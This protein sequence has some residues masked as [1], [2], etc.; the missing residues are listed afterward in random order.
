MATGT[1]TTLHFAD[2]FIAALADRLGAEA[3]ARGGDL[4]R[5]A[6]V[7]GGRRPAM[8]LLR[9]LGRRLGG[10]FFPPRCFTMDAF[11]GHALRAL[12][13][14][15]AIPMLDAWHL[16]YLLAREL[17]PGMLEGRETFSRF[18]AWARETASFIDELDIEDVAPEALATMEHCAA[19]GLD[20][21]PGVENL[22]R[23]ITAIREGYH[24]AL[25]ARKAVSRGLTYLLVS[26]GI[27][28][29]PFG[30]FDRILFCGFFSLHRTEERVVKELY[31]RG[32]ADLWFQR[33]AEPWP[34][35]ERLSKALGCP[36]EPSAG[37]TKGGGPDVSL[38]A[39]FDTQTQVGLV[40]RIVAGIPDRAGTVIV[41]PDSG[42]VIPLVSELASLEP[43]FNVSMGY[44][45]KRSALCNLLD[46]VFEAQRGMR[47]GAYY[48]R[49]YL[50]VLTHPLVKNMAVVRDG[51]LTRVLVHKIEEALRGAAGS[52]IGG[53]QF[54]RP[55]D[56]E[57]MGGVFPPAAST[58]REMGIDARPGELEAVLAGL[59]ACAFRAWEG[60]ASF[61]EFG[62][63]LES[64]VDAL[65]R[66]SALDRY[67]LN[68]TFAGRLLAMASELGGAEAGRERFEKEE[69]FKL[70]TRMLEREKISFSGSPLRGLQVLGLMETRSLDFRNVVVM[71][72]NESVLPA[73]EG[74]DPLVPRQVRVSLGLDRVEQEEEI[75][76]YHFMRLISHA[77]KVHLVYNDREEREERSRFIEELVWRVQRAKGALEAV[78]VRRARVAVSLSPPE[79]RI[80]KTEEVLRLLKDFRHSPSS[81]DTYLQCPLRFYYGYVLRLREAEDLLEEPEGADIGRFVHRLLL[82]AFTPFIGERPRIDRRFREEF[83]G[84]MEA[85]FAETFEK[86]MRADSFIL[87]EVLRVR[88]GRF[89]DAEER[90]PVASIV[91]LEEPFRGALAF[92]S[93]EH[94]FFCRADRLDREPGG[95]ILVI[96]YKTG[97]ASLPA[98]PDALAGMELARESIL[99]VVRS[100]QLPLYCRFAAERHPGDPVR[101]ALYDLT[102]SSMRDFPRARERFDDVMARCGEALGFILGEIVDPAVPFAPSPGRAC[103]WCPFTLLCR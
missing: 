58:L 13:P 50:R 1:V 81:V 100:F 96:D 60:I 85:L 14:R 69:I 33:G 74:P 18:A 71:D 29:L 4:S 2:D 38:W 75:Q 31:E 76:R 56:V 10:S 91:A 9:E 35:L 26:R 66:R 51:A 40:R 67:P 78:P 63:A 5:I 103:G 62:A 84:R 43:D 12:S 7:F 6:V 30:G 49:D 95:G 22:L 11:M 23:H 47:D 77:E 101:A 57:A 8:F 68:L 92:P 39:G 98:G 42:S 72:V 94:S 88:L 44:P 45:L 99:R 55:G 53:S 36:I 25:A 28:G 15:R 17:A 21:A 87:A 20:A 83:F 73:L 16:I 86:R 41:L 19:I 64:F 24:R 46:C 37:G 70:F 79:S 48:A 34:A 52:P 32:G 59:H 89:L 65:V 82:E 61:G 3:S 90:R 27:G 102:D 54:V 93:G 97:A 80:G